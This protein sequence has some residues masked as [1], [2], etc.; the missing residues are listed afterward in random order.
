MHTLSRSQSTRFHGTPG[1]VVFGQFVPA[2]PWRMP[3]KESAA[4]V[5]LGI[6]CMMVGYALAIFVNPLVGL[7][8]LAVWATVMMFKPSKTAES[9]SRPPSRRRRLWA[10]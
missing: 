6:M 2:R 4:S 5:F 9:H 10:R 3:L 8:P 7:I 1:F